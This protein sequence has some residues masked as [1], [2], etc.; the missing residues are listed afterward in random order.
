MG[1]GAVRP[2]FFLAWI[3]IAALATALIAM[4]LPSSL[5]VQLAL[6]VIT[7]MLACIGGWTYRR[8]RARGTAP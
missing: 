4:L 2:G 1:A 7:A 8:G 3:G 5:S 6:F